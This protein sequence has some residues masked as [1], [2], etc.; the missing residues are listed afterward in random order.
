MQP[1][2]KDSVY[3]EGGAD[4]GKIEVSSMQ[5][6]N[7]ADVEDSGDYIRRLLDNMLDVQ[8]AV[9]KDVF[10]AENDASGAEG[11]VRTS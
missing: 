8:E 11:D 2:W 7:V 1:I 4:S 3:F 9:N 10:A 6:V 5:Y